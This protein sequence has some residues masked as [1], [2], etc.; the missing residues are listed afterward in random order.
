[1]KTRFLLITFVITTFIGCKDSL[2]W[3]ESQLVYEYDYA[4]HTATVVKNSNEVQDGNVVVGYSGNISIPPYVKYYNE[5]YEVVRIK[6]GAFSYCSKLK[7]VKIPKTVI[8]IE[9]EAF[10]YSPNLDVLIVDSDNPKYDSRYECNAIIETQTNTLLFGSNKMNIPNNVTII[11]SWSI[12]GLSFENIHIPE[13]VKII[14]HHTL[15]ALP[16]LKAI[17]FPNSVGTISEDALSRCPSLKTVT[18]GKN[19]KS[20]CDAFLA[21]DKS[22]ETVTCL[23]LT[24]P[25]WL[26]PHVEIPENVI[27]YVPDQSVELYCQNQVWGKYFI[28]RPLSSK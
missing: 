3:D 11:G 18:I 28:V 9:R 22:L 1:M 7:S 25:Q 27:L 8:D 20:V 21:E 4:S 17:E 5:T 23:S 16:N 2:K 26:F 12:L 15:Q 6:Q 24:P 10:I 19:V 14:D 13:G